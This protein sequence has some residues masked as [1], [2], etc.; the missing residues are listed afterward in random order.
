[1]PNPDSWVRFRIEDIRYPTPKD[2][3]ATLHRDE[4]IVGQVVTCT[5]PEGDR[6]AFV[7]VRV[8]GLPQAVIVPVECVDALDTSLPDIAVKPQVVVRHPRSSQS[9]NQVLP[10]PSNRIQHPEQQ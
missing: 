5:Q 7:A 8:N 9:T 2:V 1:M 4:R 3:L 6:D 10:N